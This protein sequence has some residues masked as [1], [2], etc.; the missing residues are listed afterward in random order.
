MKTAPWVKMSSGNE[1]SFAV[2]KSMVQEE[3]PAPPGADKKKE[4][5][6]A[7]VEEDEAGS[8]EAGGQ[9]LPRRHLFAQ[10]DHGEAPS[11]NGVDSHQGQHHAG[12]RARLQQAA[13]DHSTHHVGEDAGDTP[14][15]TPAVVR[16]RHAAAVEEVQPDG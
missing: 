2:S 5:T 14:R 6:S 3:A 10:E 11:H 15:H 7:E 1:K 16:S 8:H 4:S 13:Q 12:L 9:D